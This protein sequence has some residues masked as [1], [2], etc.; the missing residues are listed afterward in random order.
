MDSQ[1]KQLIKWVCLKR[2]SGIWWRMNFT[3]QCSEIEVFEFW[4]ANI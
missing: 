1:Q 4:T 3:Q 2:L